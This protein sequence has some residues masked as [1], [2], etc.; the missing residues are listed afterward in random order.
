MPR[1]AQ[2]QKLAFDRIRACKPALT[3]VLLAM[4]G[5]H[6]TVDDYETAIDAIDHEDFCKTHITTLAQQAVADAAAEMKAMA[7]MN[8]TPKE[9]PDTLVSDTPA[10]S[11]SLQASSAPSI[12]TQADAIFSGPEVSPSVAES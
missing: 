5:T 3:D 10:A 9:V 2:A 4:V 8:A 12:P 11:S 1:P 6:N 7:V